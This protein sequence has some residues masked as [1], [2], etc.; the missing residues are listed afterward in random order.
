MLPSV[1]S[2]FNNVLELVNSLY[3]IQSV[4][5]GIKNSITPYALLTVLIFVYLLFLI[6]KDKLPIN[7]FCIFFIAGYMLGSCGLIFGIF[8]VLLKDNLFNRIIQIADLLVGGFFVWVGLV[9]LNGWWRLKK[10][11]AF[12]QLVVKTLLFF[13]EETVKGKQ[14]NWFRRNTLRLGSFSWGMLAALLG[15]AWPPDKDLYLMV[16]FLV[17]GNNT[18]KGFS[19]IL[20]YSF[21]QAWML[22]LVWFLLSYIRKSDSSKLWIEKRISLIKISGAAVFLAVGL[23]IFYLSIK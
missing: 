17:N 19:G 1:S 11:N 9:N 10:N 13:S 4:N 14:L 12:N 23:G 16:G 20:I 3:F 18:S 8:D 6:K 5:I 22:F 2:I 15:S 7:I 21:V